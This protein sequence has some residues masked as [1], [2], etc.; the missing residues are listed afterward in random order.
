ML[1]WSCHNQHGEG[2][3]PFL[4]NPG[5]V[6]YH[7]NF[8]SLDGEEYVVK[9]DPIRG[10][11]TK[12]RKPIRA[13]A[14]TSPESLLHQSTGFVPTNMDIDVLVDGSRQQKD[15]E[16]ELKSITPA[17]LSEYESKHPNKKKTTLPGHNLRNQIFRQ[18]QR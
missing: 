8:A 15:E 1:P 12:K 2:F 14:L 6:K 3:N 10:I 4:L 17:Q 18:L 5:E 11:L 16:E 13:P 7:T 9:E